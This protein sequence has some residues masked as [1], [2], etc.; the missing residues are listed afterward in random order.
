[1]TVSSLH[2]NSLHSDQISVQKSNLGMWWNRRFASWVHRPHICSNCATL[3]CQ[4]GTNVCMCFYYICVSLTS[5]TTN[6]SSTCLHL[7]FPHANG[8]APGQVQQCDSAKVI[9]HSSQRVAW[10]QTYRLAMPPRVWE[11]KSARE[12]G[13]CVEVRLGFQSQQH[14]VEDD[15]ICGLDVPVRTWYLKGW[16]AP[17]WASVSGEP[18]LRSCFCSI[19]TTRWEGNDQWRW[20][21]IERGKRKSEQERVRRK[22]QTQIFRLQ[23]LS[24]T[25]TTDFGLE[26]TSPLDEAFVLAAC[27]S[28]LIQASKNYPF[29]GSF[30]WS[31]KTLDR[32]WLSCV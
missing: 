30:Y 18:P 5:L 27:C 10:G 17:P 4:Y 3:S 21:K 31:P 6:C 1:M 23:M 14:T 29:V 25:L 24:S 20:K 32:F 26:T 19:P 22:L 2:S 9:S 7:T 8:D 12:S 11:T 28:A 16:Q 13:K 15:W